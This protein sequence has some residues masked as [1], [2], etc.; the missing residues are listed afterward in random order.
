MRVRGLALAVRVLKG[1]SLEK[2]CSICW[3]LS[4]KGGLH[5]VSKGEHLKRR[6]CG[7]AIWRHLWERCCVA[8][9]MCPLTPGTS[10]DVLI[11]DCG[12]PQRAKAILKIMKWVPMVLCPLLY[13][14]CGREL[15][16]PAEPEK[17]HHAKDA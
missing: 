8:V 7:A 4:I 9:W 13:Y 6:A 14:G 15:L 11:W 16:Q 5:G 12:G 10:A 3:V 2:H 1:P 17:A